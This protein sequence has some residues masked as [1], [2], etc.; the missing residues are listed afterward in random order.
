MIDK[1]LYWLLQ[2]KMYYYFGK[3]NGLVPFVYPTN[4]NHWSIWSIAT[5]IYSAT[6]AFFLLAIFIYTHV[7]I[8]NDLVTNCNDKMIISIIV[9]IAAMFSIVRTIGIY[10]IQYCQHNLHIRLIDEA[11]ELYNQF[12]E[13]FS[14]QIFVN[15]SF[16]GYYICKTV[17]FIIQAIVI[18]LPIRN[19]IPNISQEKNIFDMS[20]YI[21]FFMAYSS[22]VRSI[23]TSYY[24]CG[25][26]VVMQFYQKINE[27]I[28][29]LVSA[30]DTVEINKKNKQMKL[31]IYFDLSDRFDVMTCM[32]DRVTDFM[33]KL[34][35]AFSINLVMAV[36][37]CFLTILYEVGKT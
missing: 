29:R 9:V 1:F 21:S 15:R 7:Y 6:S 37:E 24:F 5:K 26:L 33:N 17:F 25:M 11:N 16:I 20:L 30:I 31:Q 36:M 13:I 3:L 18:M 4:H 2:I 23:I 35:G 12:M 22:I 34:N 14:G 10:V 8:L 32:F 19:Y 27:E 28:L